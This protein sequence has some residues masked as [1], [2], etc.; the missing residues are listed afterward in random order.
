M[1]IIIDIPEKTYKFIY[2]TGGINMLDTQMIANAIYD[3]VKLPEKIGRLIDADALE[4]KMLH[5]FSLPGYKERKGYRRRE[6]EVKTALINTP[7]I[8]E[9]NKMIRKIKKN[10]LGYNG[11]CDWCGKDQPGHT[12]QPYIVYYKAED[13]KRGNNLIACCEECAKELYESL[14]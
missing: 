3:G 4:L 13:E 1:K 12:K 6:K 7:S 8:I 9:G 14:R 10:N 2:Q 5:S 11:C